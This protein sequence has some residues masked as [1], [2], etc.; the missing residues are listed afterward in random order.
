MKVT[1]FY[2]QFRIRRRFGIDNRY[3]RCVQI[4]VHEFRMVTVIEQTI[5]YRN[6]LHFLLILCLF[7][8]RR[9]Q[10][11][12]HSKH[13]RT[14]NDSCEGHYPDDCID[15]DFLVNDRVINSEDHSKGN[16]SSDHASISNEYSF[17]DSDVGSVA[18]CIQNLKKAYRHCEPHNNY[19][20]GHCNKEG[21]RTVVFIVCEESKA[22]AA[23]NKGFKS[24]AQSL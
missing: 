16:S 7:L 22:Q 13:K 6:Q 2:C 8:L 9:E 12:K 18:K 24:I 21:D 10:Q 20:D 4:R 14:H 15:D 11:F 3:H 19:Y 17:F 5:F 1:Q 23:E